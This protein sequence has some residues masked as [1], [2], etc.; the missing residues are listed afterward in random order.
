MNIE[1]TA[2]HFHAPDE[3]REYAEEE[4]LRI[5]R[6]F[7][8]AVNCHII[9]EHEHN[10]YITELNLLMP[11]FSLN[12]KETSVNVKESIDKA[13]DKMMTRVTKAKEKMLSH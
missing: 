13:V 8:R 5:N 3:V 7:D 12:V 2:R 1:F 9:L 10:E 6:V 4:V 11:Q